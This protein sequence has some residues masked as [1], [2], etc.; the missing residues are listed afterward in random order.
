MEIFETVQRKC[1]HSDNWDL[2]KEILNE[3]EPNN[4]DQIRQL[5]LKW[6]IKI[7]HWF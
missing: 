3:M 7:I 2:T 6:F 5:K 1:S 4:E